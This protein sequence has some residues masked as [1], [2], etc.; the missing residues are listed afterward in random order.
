MARFLL[1]AFFI[2]H[3]RWYLSIFSVLIKNNEM[4]YTKKIMLEYVIYILLV[5]TIPT[6]FHWLTCRKQKLVQ[7]KTVQLRLFVL[8]L[9]FWQWWQVFV[10]YLM[11]VL[12]IWKWKRGYKQTRGLSSSLYE[13][14]LCCDLFWK[15]IGSKNS[16]FIGTNNW[17]HGFRD[18]VLVRKL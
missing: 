6:R 14:P 18:S 10:H 17:I 12:M 5:E 8:I 3:L 2:E 9:G 7:S 1:P 13:I 4:V 16:L 11:S 15:R